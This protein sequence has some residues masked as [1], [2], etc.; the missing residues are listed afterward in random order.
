MTMTQYR[1]IFLIAVALVLTAG[2][3]LV[4]AQE[5]DLAAS[6]AQLS[7]K[8]RSEARSLLQM[9]K[10]RMGNP[11]LQRRG[12]RYILQQ[13]DQL[14]IDF[15]LAPAFNQ[16]ETVQPDGYISL[17]NLGELHAAG[18]TVPELTDA[19]KREYTKIM[20]DPTITVVLKDF[21]HPYFIASGQIMKPGK[22]DLRGVTTVAQAVAIAGGFSRVAKRSHV[23]LFRRVS[24]DHIEVKRFDF[25]KMLDQGKLQ[26]D[27]AL[28]P[29]DLLFVPRSG[30]A[31]VLNAL[32][33]H[34]STGLY[35]PLRP[36]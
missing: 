27:I 18:N 2:A 30:T 21:E 25:K 33:P 32:F 34:T 28:R 19:L 29:G 13:G 26:E 35:V 9:I 22:Y 8:Q 5:Q 3:S 6:T 7:H 20:R 12:S 36:Y 31:A 17:R 4:S 23:M 11:V 14:E 24:G 16:V 1:K 10:Q 15:P